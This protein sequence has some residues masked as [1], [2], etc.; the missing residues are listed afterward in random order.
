MW[1]WAILG[2]VGAPLTLVLHELAHVLVARAHGIRIKTFRPW[3]HFTTS[4]F[5]WGSV[6]YHQ[7]LMPAQ[8]RMSALAPLIKAISLMLAWAFLGAA[9]SPLWALAAWEAIDVINWL[10]GYLRMSRNDGGTYRSLT[11]IGV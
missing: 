6:S 4:G 9:W 1:Y 3:P 8:R 7:V 2:V 10:Q 5:V 11:A